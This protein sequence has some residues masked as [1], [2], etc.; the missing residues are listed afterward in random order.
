MRSVCLS[1]C[2]YV[3]VIGSGRCLSEHCLWLAVC[4]YVCV[5]VCVW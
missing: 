1:V 5:S 3:G 4:L 2:L